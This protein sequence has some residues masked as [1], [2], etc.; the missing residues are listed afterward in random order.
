MKQSLHF[1]LLLVL[2][3]SCEETQLTE[4]AWIDRAD[5]KT[6]IHIEGDGGKFWVRM[7]DRS[8]LSDRMEILTRGGKN[9]VKHTPWELPIKMDSDGSSLLFRDAQYIPFSKSMKGKFTGRWK[10][11]ATGLAFDVRIDDNIEI[12]WD[13]LQEG[14]NPVRFWPK[15]TDEGFYFTR[16]HEVWSFSMEEGVM[17]DANGNRYRKIFGYLT[18]PSKGMVS[19]SNE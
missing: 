18:I 15:R 2:I 13:V 10:S 19:Y 11:E 14:L 16:D 9:F 5:E 4:G 3:T 1:L 17:V 8:G 6:L 7:E 12:T